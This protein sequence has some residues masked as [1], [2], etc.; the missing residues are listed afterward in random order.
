MKNLIA[1]LLLAIIALPVAADSITIN[2]RAAYNVEVQWRTWHLGYEGNVEDTFILAGQSK[3]LSYE[4]ASWVK[5]RA[6]IPGYGWNHVDLDDGE[7]HH[8]LDTYGTATIFNPPKFYWG[9]K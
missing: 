3:T 6:N 9:T 5:V 7:I 8:V 4:E 2:N 1:S